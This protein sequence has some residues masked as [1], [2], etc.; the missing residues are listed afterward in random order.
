[1]AHISN[2]SLAMQLIRGNFMLL[3]CILSIDELGRY[4]DAI[5]PMLCR[6]RF[7]MARLGGKHFYT[8]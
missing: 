1:M 4:V 5:R 2:V 6:R 3:F 8:P 7:C